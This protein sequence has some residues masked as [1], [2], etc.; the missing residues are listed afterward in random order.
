MEIELRHLRY[1]VAVAEEGSFTAGARRLHVAQQVLSTQIRQVESALGV[2][3]LDRTT[4]GIRL[5][6][7]GEAFL[8]GA[9][10]AL[11]AV[12]NA[13][14]S[15]RNAAGALTGRLRVGLH[16]AASGDRPSQILAGFAARN[17]GLD[18]PLRTFELDQPAAGLLDGS[19]DVAFIRAPVTAAGL[20]SVVVA[21]EPR[22]FVLPAGHPLTAR[23]VLTL[24]DTAGLPWIAAA[25]AR[26]GSPP[27]T[28][29]DEWLM[30][31]RP[32]GEH[33][34]VGAVAVTLD[35]WREH[36][37]AGRG[38]SL[39]PASSE[40]YYARPGIAFVPARGVPPA[41]THLAWRTSDKREVVRSL[42]L[43]A[44]ADG[45]GG[46]DGAPPDGQAGQPSRAYP[47]TAATA[48][49][50]MSRSSAPVIAPATPTPPA[51]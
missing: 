9:R 35:E 37:A 25:A 5:S 17:P 27:E 33:P 1:F 24:A 3:L 39:C 51:T 2:V 8:D 43:F 45:A 19:S 47:V 18:M 50:A 15:A 36:V 20:A 13:V 22:V 21:T 6:A 30:V 40:R 14:E 49:S 31:P 26:D 46:A 4:R 48:A 29:R 7:A 34:V 16:V 11:L 32:G 10:V 28:W 42:A 41:R 38:I 12:G 44:A 23:P